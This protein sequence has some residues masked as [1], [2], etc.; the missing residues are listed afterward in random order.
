ME[1]IRFTASSLPLMAQSGHRYRLDAR[2]L[3]RAERTLCV[4]ARICFLSHPKHQ[5]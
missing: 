3:L 1:T 2:L 4:V 5:G